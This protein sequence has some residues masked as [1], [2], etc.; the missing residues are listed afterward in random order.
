MCSLTSRRHCDPYQRLTG[1]FCLCLI[2]LYLS[3]LQVSRNILEM[4]RKVLSRPYL[5]STSQKLQAQL[6]PITFPNTASN[7]NLIISKSIQLFTAKIATNFMYLNVNI[8]D[9]L[10]FEST[11]SVKHFNQHFLCIT[12]HFREKGFRKCKLRSQ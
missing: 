4:N 6:W 7:W 1:W 10:N 5:W 11:F 3:N 2:P 9:I 12:V 8:S